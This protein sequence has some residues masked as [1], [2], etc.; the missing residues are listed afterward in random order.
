MSKRT[1]S[2]K[3]TEAIKQPAGQARVRRPVPYR[4]RITPAGLTRSGSRSTDGLAFPGGRRI[5][6]P[7]D[8][9]AP[10]LRRSSLAL[11]LAAGCAAAGGERR[12]RHTAPAAAAA[13][14]AAAR[15]HRGHRLDAPAHRRQRADHPT[16][17]AQQRGAPPALPPPRARSRPTSRSTRRPSSPPARRAPT[18]SRPTTRR[19]PSTCARTWSGATACRSPPT[20]CAG[21][22]RPR[23]TPT[24]AWDERLHEGAHH[25]RRGGGPAHRALPLQPGLRQAAPGRQRGRHPA[26]ARLGEAPFAEV[27]RE[28][29]TGSA[30]NLV[31][32]GPFTIASWE[33]QQQVVL[34]RNQR[35]Y[36]EGPPLPGP[37]GPAHR[38]PTRAA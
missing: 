29:A 11:L 28:R 22:G 2:P 35:Y 17:T 34:V 36:D 33:P 9:L 19:S 3:T 31:V 30:Q 10:S 26:Q 15:R 23:S 4:Q 1:N 24:S 32:S 27:A 20:T 16:S 21:P 6:C 8:R 25:R 5:R 38:S 13:G 12:S 14:D 7:L 18:S 37:G